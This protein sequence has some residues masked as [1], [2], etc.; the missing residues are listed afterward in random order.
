MGTEHHLT[1]WL[2]DLRRLY[3]LR[4]ICFCGQTIRG[5]SWSSKYVIDLSRRSMT[6]RHCLALHI[7]VKTLSSICELPSDEESDPVRGQNS[8]LCHSCQR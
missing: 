1:L 3:I 5:P 4:S 8:R 6:I 2:A 7:C